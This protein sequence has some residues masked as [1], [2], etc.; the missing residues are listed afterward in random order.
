MSVKL[1]PLADYIV[2]QNEEP[3][4]ITKS[5]IYIPSDSNAEK[6]KICKVLAVGNNVKSVKISDR[7][8]YKSYSSTEVKIENSE[9]IIVKEE[10][11][12]AIVK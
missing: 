2:A 1:E 11:V 5:G 3:Q 4:S 6:P 12:L 10:D 9:Y 7:I 8:V